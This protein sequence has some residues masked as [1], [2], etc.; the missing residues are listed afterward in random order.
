[1]LYHAT[2]SH[3]VARRDGAA[4][5]NA[6]DFGEHVRGNDAN[7]DIANHKKPDFDCFAP[8]QAGAKAQGGMGETLPPLY[9]R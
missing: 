6:A 7:H 3:T 1:M 9:Y 2:P 5:S 4:I 8:P